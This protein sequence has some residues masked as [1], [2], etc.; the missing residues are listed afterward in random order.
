ME[1]YFFQCPYCWEQI[2]MLV[3][4]SQNHQ[5]YIEDCEICCNPIQVS[6]VVENQ[7][8]I[9]FEAKNIEQ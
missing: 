9:N 3:D 6:I 1:E 7:E 5:N 4:T 8:I 2:S